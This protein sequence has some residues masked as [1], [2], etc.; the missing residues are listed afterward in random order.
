MKKALATLGVGGEVSR[1]RATF[2]ELQAPDEEAGTRIG[3]TSDGYDRAKAAVNQT[4]VRT[5]DLGRNG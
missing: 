2:L 5:A 4:I 3:G 1:E